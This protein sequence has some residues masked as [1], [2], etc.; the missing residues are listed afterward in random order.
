MQTT[1]RKLLLCGLLAILLH[2]SVRADTEH[3]D[4]VLVEQGRFW[5]AQGDQKRA[6]E[7]WNKLLLLEPGSA[8]ALY[9]L[10]TVELKSGRPGQARVY[11]QRMQEAQPNSPLLALLEQDIH[12]HTG[13]NMATLEEARLLAASLELDDALVKYRQALAGRNPV[14]DVGREYYGYLGYTDGGLDEAIAGLRRLNTRSPGDP[15]TQLLLA[16]HLARNESTRLDGIRRLASLSKRADIGSDAAESW[17]DAL[18]WLKVPQPEALPLFVEYL[19]K[20]PDDEEIRAQLAEG[21]AAFRKRAA[22]AAKRESDKV[23]P[24]APRVDPLRTRTDAAMKLLEAGDTGRARAE[25]EAVLNQRPNDSE[26]LGGLGIVA[27][28]AGNWREAHDYLTRARRGNAAWQASLD[29]VQYWIDIE[30]AQALLAA[31]NSTEARKLAERAI[32][33]NSRE[34][35]AHR[36]LADILAH[37]GKT[38]QAIAAYRTLLGR[39]PDVADLRYRLAFLHLQA[40]NGAEAT[41]LLEDFLTENPNDPD[42]LY[43]QARLLSESG[44]WSEARVALERIPVQQ[45]S[46][47]MDQL[48]DK[49]RSYLRLSEAAALAQAGKKAEALSL[50]ERLGL[51]SQDDT[52]MLS[53]VSQLYVE[54]GETERALSLLTPLRAQADNRSVDASIAY[55]GLLL[56]SDQDV[57]ASIILR[58][59]RTESL[60]ASQQAQL[61]GLW[62]AYQIHSANAYT[63]RGDL[64]GGYDVLAPVIQRRPN[65]P[66]ALA[67][68]ARMHAAAGDSDKALSLYETALQ[69]N[70]NSATL[71]LGMA[72]LALQLKNTRRAERAVSAA[73]SL[74]PQNFRILTDAAQIYGS[75]GQHDKA[76][77][78]SERARALARPSSPNISSYE[79]VFKR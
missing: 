59:L 67:A 9:G 31:E 71:H 58:R 15:Q 7:A 16:R 1:H 18:V 33:K 27:M 51:E 66:G 22:E 3:A 41:R 32:R 77:Q 68:L 75:M 74:A 29:T 54:L 36:L 56:A 5:Q 20:Y 62:D 52:V 49:A 34:L 26:A 42:A 23:T 72:R 47:P 46:I 79:N 43:A 39:F 44:Q 19:A 21:V 28:R 78:L 45:R 53:R 48:Y 30:D 24:I 61:D 60:T 65:D 14:G 2:Q 11:L 10:A 40:G 17:R 8:R 70:P 13:D 50:L 6:A 37:E 63:E 38:A 57:E 73:L 64:V 12:L 76:S 69:S 35:A 55:A 25:L 4:Q